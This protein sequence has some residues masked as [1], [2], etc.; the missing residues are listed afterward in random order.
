MISNLL[1][2]GSTVRRE[3]PAAGSAA[4]VR[5]TTPA[6]APCQP[7]PAAD[8]DV[9][10]FP[11]SVAQ[12]RF[13]LLD[14]LVPGGNTALNMPLALRLVGD[15][16]LPA[17]ERAC[18]E[19]VRRHETLRTTF[20]CE[21]GHLL[22]VITPRQTV[23]VS[24]V[25]VSNFPA[26][27]R[28][29]VPDHLLAEEARQPFDLARGPLLRLRLVRLAPR[30]HLLLCPMHHIIADG[31]SNGV[32]VA[33]LGA[34]YTA[35]AGNKPSPLKEPAV[36]FADFS[37]WQDSLLTSGGFDAQM[38][39]WR[40]RLAGQLPVLDLPVDRPRLPSH[41]Q[42]AVSAICVRR[43]PF[44]LTVALKAL[45]VREGA[46]PFMVFLAAFAVLLNRYAGGQEDLVVGTSTANR[47]RLEVENLI[48]LFVNPLLLRLDLSGAP[49]FREL[50]AR[51]RR[52]TLEAFENADAPFEKLIELLQPRR[53]QVNFLYQQD[54]V[55]SARWL[56]LEVIPVE[57]GSGGAVYEWNLLGVE[58][59]A[60]VRLHCEYNAD[61]FTAETIARVLHDYEG[62]LTAVAGDGLDRA[63]TVLPFLSTVTDPAT[64]RLLRAEAWRLPSPTVAWMRAHLPPASFPGTGLYAPPPGRQ[65]TVLDAHDQPAP[66]S[67]PGELC[68][69][70]DSGDEP[71]K[72]G[73]IAC[74][75]A[76]GTIDWIGPSGTECKVDGLRVDRRRTEEA[77]CR[78]PHVRQA[79]VLWRDDEK[80]KPL[81]TAYYQGDGVPLAL[82]GTRE[83]HGFLQDQVADEW[84]PGAFVALETFPL[85]ADGRL[86]EGALPAPTVERVS[87]CAE[88]HDVP[89]LPL[90]HQII[91]IWRE[92]LH[93][94]SVS[95][96]DDFFALGGNS[97]LAM[98]MLYQVEQVFGK[99]LL[100]ATLF[101]RATVEN[102]ADE[103]LKQADEPGSR[104][105]VRVQEAG[106]KPPLFFLHG[107]IAGGGFYCRKLSQG[108]GDDQPFYALP[109]M[110]IVDPL[111]DRPTVQAMAAVHIATIRTVRP[112]GPYVIGGFCLGGL[113]AYEIACQL[114]RE[115]EKVERLIVIDA[116][117]ADRR[118]ATLRRWVERMARWRRLDGNRQLHLFCRW[119]YW[120]ARWDRFQT[121]DLR[122]RC[123]GFLRQLRKLVRR[124]GPVTLDPAATPQDPSSTAWFDPRLDVPLIFLWAVG[125]YQP[126]FYAGAMTL[127]LSSDVLDGAEGGNPT[128]AWRRIVPDLE[129]AELQGNHLACITEHVAG[130]AATLRRRLDRRRRI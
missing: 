103:I 99:A 127:L 51:V 4:P 2:A 114:E 44:A 16:H 59:A 27:E 92:L 124:V 57:P 125:G 108:L 47:D 101:Q 31:W 112:Q 9:F 121:F 83:L 33:E 65:F 54:F 21:K 22:Q 106:A 50:L 8:E 14:Q 37:Q 70:S 11:A 45:A 111:E 130:L 72:T 104:E 19:I 53:L 29:R 12:R 58:D 117:P 61:L 48:G 81:L 56:D 66:E 36:Q 71:F 86:D 32:F 91:E 25:D 77:L 123:A 109:P 84:I 26:A 76:D 15:L 82:L 129:T 90:H 49:T 43:L 10:I 28:A 69:V 118:L 75:R 7:D 94:R 39:Y 116:G 5:G 79:V 87:A 68:L 18:Q 105:V 100:P 95:I 73:D 60:G 120:L 88:S 89:Y 85:T 74:L 113:I 119:H 23:H 67:V 62:L 40:G 1:D 107:D 6:A 93:V 30:E 98:R 41:R 97:L 38:D 128:P 102:L 20:H 126:R 63:I 64:R 96:R 35:F 122:A 115:G 42:T 13:W 55:Q 46:S 24:V 3:A 17:L 110:E 34:L 52:T 80:G 78:H